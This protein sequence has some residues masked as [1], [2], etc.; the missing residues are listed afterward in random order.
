MYSWSVSEG[1]CEG[2]V[3]DV[4]LYLEEFE[5]EYEHADTGTE[6]PAQS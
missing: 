6:I 5:D 4:G 3:V 1:L 2:L